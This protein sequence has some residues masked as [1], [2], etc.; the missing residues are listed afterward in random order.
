MNSPNKPTFDAS[1]FTT[2][3]AKP[4]PVILLLD[5]SASMSEIVGGDYTLTGETVFEDGKEWSLAKG[6]VTRIQLLNE[7]VK[8]M[9]ATLKKEESMGTEF[10]VSIITFGA[11][12]RLQVPPTKA[13]DVN[14]ADLTTDGETPLGAA[15]ALAKEL[16]EDKERMPSR[17][18]RP[19][20]VLVSDGKPTDIWENSL[21]EFTTLG[22][23][24]KCD[25]I[26]MAIGS[27][28]DKGML[29]KFIEG[30]DNQVFE[31]EQAQEVHEFFKKVTMSVVARLHSQNP[32]LVPSDSDIRLD[33]PSKKA[34]TGSPSGEQEAIE[35]EGYW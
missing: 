20:V 34:G 6:G 22:R 33:G 12:S 32:N 3:S 16:V 14:W 4:L 23:S 19:T 30:T 29:E 10:L 5:V 17:A 1:S 28:A 11:D 24:A 27:E 31:A 26:A 9:L 13:N 35:D 2:S 18:Y 7:A 8:K 25:R 15:M 21:A